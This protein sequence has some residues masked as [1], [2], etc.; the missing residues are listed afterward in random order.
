MSLMVWGHTSSRFIVL[1]PNEIAAII[2]G[3]SDQPTDGR[4]IIL[5]R[6]AEQGLKRISELHPFYPALHYV[7][8]FST[9]QLE[10]HH[11]LT[12][13]NGAE[14]DD[15]ENAE[16]P[17]PGE[18]TAGAGPSKRK[19]MSMQ[20]F[21]A[22]HLHSRE[23]SFNHLF[24]SGKLFHEYLVDSWAT[25]E[26]NRLKYLHS[27]QGQLC[28]DLYSTLTTAIQDNPG[29]D[30]ANLGMHI[31][32][33]STFT[34]STRNLQTSCQDALA[35]NHYFKGANLFTTMTANPNWPEIRSAL[36]PGQ[37]PGD[38]PDIVS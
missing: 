5:H 17:P 4:D 8:L 2:P 1:F 20:E 32:L 18:E 22:F 28:S 11:Q 34:G 37:Q 35:L 14:A 9:G 7:L 15:Q 3:S 25:C 26:K 12:Y 21:L 6:K 13:Q 33:P 10:W 38:R 36:L 19:H 29:A 16:Q 23:Q 27:N 31:I 24:H 30:P